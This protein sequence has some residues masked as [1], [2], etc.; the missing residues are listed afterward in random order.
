MSK[1]TCREFLLSL[2]CLIFCVSLLSTFLSSKPFQRIVKSLMATFV[3]IELKKENLKD[4]FRAPEFGCPNWHISL[5]IN[6]DMSLF[7]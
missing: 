3:E 7:R 2:Q 1:N 5:P 4:A 6:L